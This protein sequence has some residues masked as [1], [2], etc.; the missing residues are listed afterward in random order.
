MPL[1]GPCA[2]EMPKI[3]VDLRPNPHVSLKGD[4]SFGDRYENGKEGSPSTRR[5]RPFPKFS[6]LASPSKKEG[7]PKAAAMAA[8]ARRTSW[9]APKQTLSLGPAFDKSWGQTVLEYMTCSG[10]ASVEEIQDLIK[11]AKTPVTLH[12]YAVGHAKAIQEI[13]YVVEN[14]LPKGVFFMAPSRCSGRSSALGAAGGTSAASSPA[15]PRSAPCILT[16]KVRFRRLRQ[17]LA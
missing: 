15:S 1:P 17:R 8:P 2:R 7:S 6:A 4:M 3:V 11:D 5:G 10:G 9:A 14:F 13:N 16:E 12:V